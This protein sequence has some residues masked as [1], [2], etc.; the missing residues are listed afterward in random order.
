MI[1]TG[2]GEVKGVGR[3]VEQQI[4]LRTA[5]MPLFLSGQGVPESLLGGLRD[6]SAGAGDLSML[7]FLAELLTWMSA[8]L[9]ALKEWKDG[10][11]SVSME[12]FG[13][14][15]RVTVSKFFQ[16]GISSGSQA[17]AFFAPPGLRLRSGNDAG[18]EKEVRFPFPLL[19]KIAGLLAQPPVRKRKGPPKNSSGLPVPRNTRRPTG[20]ANAPRNAK[21]TK[22]LAEAGTEMRL[23]PTDYPNALEGLRDRSRHDRVRATANKAIFLP[24]RPKGS[25]NV[26]QF[27]L[28]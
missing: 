6:L 3:L 27:Q 22:V 21:A 19:L 11:I 1:A 7:D 26:C 13:G 23:D 5:P 2:L 25:P 10:G 24:I 12:A 4:G 18:L 16:D 14:Q 20:K 15:M 8:N 9:D 28:V 17:I